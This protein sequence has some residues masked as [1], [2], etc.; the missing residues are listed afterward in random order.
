M[1]QFSRRRYVS[2]GLIV[3]C[4]SAAGRGAIAGTTSSREALLRQ[5]EGLLANLQAPQAL[6]LFER[7]ALMA[8]SCDTE[9]GIVRAHMQAGH[10]QRAIAFAAHAA[11]AHV[12]EVEATAL[13]A[14]LLW[15]GGQQAMALRLLED[16]QARMTDSPVLASVQRRLKSSMPLAPA[17]ARIGTAAFRLHPYG[18]TAGMTKGAKVIGTGL[19]CDAGRRALVPLNT[20]RNASANLWVRTALGDCSKAVVERRGPVNGVAVVRLAEA[21]KNG[22]DPLFSI[23]AAFPG[24]IGYVVDFVPSAQGAPAWPL[25]KS[26]FLGMSLTGASET[27]RS[28]NVGPPDGPS[29]GAVFDKNGVVV[30]MALPNH[31]IILSSELLRILGLQSAETSAMV[32]KMPSRNSDQIYEQSLRCVAQIIA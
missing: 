32:S 19:L 20:L 26:G 4:F 25:L 29:G 27:T 14:W 12:D 17:P 10:Y 30:G 8:H 24:S 11:G 9:M 22:P 16:A 7:A 21:I 1:I 2:G 6:V 5:A 31:Q 23:R 3:G 28:I 15:V 13:Y 18:R